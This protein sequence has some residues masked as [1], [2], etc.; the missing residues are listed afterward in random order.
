MLIPKRLRLS[1]LPH[2]EN[3]HSQS[4]YLWRSGN[5]HISRYCSE[6]VPGRVKQLLSEVENVNSNETLPPSTGHSELTSTSKW[7][8]HSS[9]KSTTDLHLNFRI[10]LLLELSL[11]LM[12]LLLQVMITSAA[13][14][15]T[16]I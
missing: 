7:T 13:Q 8:E 1:Q 2:L 10:T 5:G 4:E 15:K 11:S 6:E 12:L 16:F 3:L 9:R 14:K